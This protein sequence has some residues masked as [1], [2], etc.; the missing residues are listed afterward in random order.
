[1]L[2]ISV[3]NNYLIGAIIACLLA[4][5]TKNTLITALVSMGVF[6]FML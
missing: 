2:N 3:D 6:F 5:F 1:M 4:Y